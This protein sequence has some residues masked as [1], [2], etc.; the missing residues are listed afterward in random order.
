MDRLRRILA[1]G[2]LALTLSAA[3]A[4]TGCRSTGNEIPPQP[5]YTTPGENPSAIGF[6]SAPHG[7]NGVGSVYANGGMPS[8]PG[9]GGGS[10]APGAGGLG[11]GAPTDGLPAVSANGA[12]SAFGTPPPSQGNPTLPTGNVYG[13][14]GTAGLP[15]GAG[16]GGYGGGLGGAGGGGGMGGR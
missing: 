8:Q 4:S 2:T 13:G 7:Y 12:G 6:N 1:G 5:K 11:M 10:G 14:P 9:L 3:V 15:G 16:A